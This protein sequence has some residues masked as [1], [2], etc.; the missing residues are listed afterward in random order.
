MSIPAAQEVKVERG[1]D[2]CQY[3][4][5]LHVTKRNNPSP[6]VCLII[7]DV[8]ICLECIRELIK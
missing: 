5:H 1:K 3:H 4:G 8:P 6:V 7:N 2:W